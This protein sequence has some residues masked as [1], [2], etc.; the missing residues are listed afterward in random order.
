MQRINALQIADID[1][2]TKYMVCVLDHQGLIFLVTKIQN[3]E[4]A[5][6]LVSP[7]NVYI[8]VAGR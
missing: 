6:R 8:A 2:D 7:K 1:I 3:A 5:Y 4:W